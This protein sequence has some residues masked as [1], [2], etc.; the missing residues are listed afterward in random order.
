[1]NTSITGDSFQLSMVGSSTSISMSGPTT[2]IQLAEGGVDIKNVPLTTEIILGADKIQVK[3]PG[4]ETKI[5]DGIV[6]I[7]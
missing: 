4:I 1:M 3:A 5:Y 2:N 6:L 7:L